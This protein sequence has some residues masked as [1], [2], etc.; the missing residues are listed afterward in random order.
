MVLLK[1]AK[2]KDG[3]CDMAK[4]RDGQT[5][6]DEVEEQY[7][8]HKKMQQAGYYDENKSKKERLSIIERVKNAISG[9]RGSAGGGGMNPTD[10]EKVPGKRQLKMAKGGSIKSSASKRADGIA[11]RGKTKGRMV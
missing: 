3:W 5:D 10:I 2:L 1:K 4:V 6:P 8:R 7:Q 9:G 11:Q